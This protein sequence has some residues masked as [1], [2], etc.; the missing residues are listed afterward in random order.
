MTGVGSAGSGQPGRTSP[1]PNHH[2]P[3]EMTMASPS[4]LWG[5]PL[6]QVS[7]P[8]FV[9]PHN[10]LQALAQAGLESWRLPQGWPSWP[11][12]T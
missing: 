12:L 8:N 1:T 2:H 10:E 5:S 9:T 7:S 4:L 6:L 3:T 11:T